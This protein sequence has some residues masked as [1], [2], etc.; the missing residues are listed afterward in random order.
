MIKI[1]ARCGIEFESRR[2]VYCEDCRQI[3]HFEYAN[4]YKRTH[5]E[6]INEYERRYRKTHRDKINEYQRR[7]YETHREQT[8]EYQRRYREKIKLKLIR[9][10]LSA[11]LKGDK[12][13]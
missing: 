8:N 13:T 7:Y 3:R 12:S 1:C 11:T 4:R 2:S 6:Q 10:I 9:E 5:R